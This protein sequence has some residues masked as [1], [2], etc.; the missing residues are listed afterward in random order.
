MRVSRYHMPTLKEA[1]KD[2][3][4]ASHSYLIR[5]GFIRQVAAGIYD[6]MPMGVKVLHKVEQIVREEMNRYGGI[7]VLLPA[8]Q[9]SELWKESGRWGYY[10][11]ELLRLRDR[12]DR[13]FCV[14]PTHEEVITDLVRRDVRSYRDLPI[15]LYQIQ[16][17]FRDEIKPRGGLMRGREFIMK[18][19]YSF[20]ANEEGAKANYEL[21]YKA[22][23]AIF[24]R[25]GLDFRVVEADTG[26][27]GGS[28]SHEFQVVAETGEDYVLK[29]PECDFTVNQ[30]LGPLPELAAPVAPAPLALEEV[31]TPDQKSVEEV[32][33]FLTVETSQVVK[34]LICVVD[35][36]PMAVLLRGDHELSDVKLRRALGAD[37][38]E[39]ADDATVER[40]SGAA[41][42]F[43]GPVGLA[44]KITVVADLAVQGM[45]NVVVGAN[46]ESYHLKNA[47][48]DRDFKIDR[49]VDV[50]TA[51]DGDA[52]PNCEAGKYSLF[53][54]IEVGHIFYLGTKY[55]K[56]MACTVLNEN[57]KPQ[58]V[59]MGCY[60]IGVTR[61]ISAAI[62]QNHDDKGIVWPV[63]LAPFEVA[64][65]AL[66]MKD[67]AVAATSESFYS[68]LQERG[69]DVLFDDRKQRPGFKFADAELIGFPYLIVV[70][71][72][73]V[74]EGKVEVKCRRT[75][76][77][78]D[79]ATDEAVNYVAEQIERERR[80]L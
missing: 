40:V 49:F 60:G 75:G 53:R 12:H 35:D 65:L 47:N 56:A 23:S 36:E 13:E 44:E 43:A 8:V 52:C 15:N 73:G 14:G 62:E 30:E 61:I 31:H 39:M 64:V 48:P 70:G 2:A 68:E 20:D 38:V 37:Q 69:V 59:E 74:A 25:C 79:I 67:E 80:G 51:V 22:Y 17:K 55:S 1:P 9:P 32:A 4:L 72:R 78:L 50:R 10:G 18:D 24:S 7:E 77:K 5:G 34:T 26:N 57:G 29:C 27:I 11:P 58:P 3:E 21:M 6:F 46:K 71:S 45:G 41:V 42:G 33:E 63:P 54:G 19:A 16:T 28:M 66:Q 76:E